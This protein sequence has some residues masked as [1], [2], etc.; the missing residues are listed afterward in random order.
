VLYPYGPDKRDL[1]I[2]PSILLPPHWKQGSA[3][4]VTSQSGDRV[5]FAPV[6]LERLID[7]PFLAGELFRAVPLASSWPEELDIT[8]GRPG[9]FGTQ[10]TGVFH[11]PWHIAQSAPARPR[12]FLMSA[13]ATPPPDNAVRRA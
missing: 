7:S 11:L 2:E 10:S 5:N 4:R 13:S 8:G 3:L 6:S 1:M 9:L 12:S